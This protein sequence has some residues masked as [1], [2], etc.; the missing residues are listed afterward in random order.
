MRL[1]TRVLPYIFE[2][3]DWRG[4]FWS[5][6]PGQADDNEV[7]TNKLTIEFLNF[8]MPENFAV[9]YLKFKQRGQTLGYFVK[10]MQ[11]DLQTVKTLIRLLQNPIWV[12]T[13][14][15]NLFVR[16]LRIITVFNLVARKAILGISDQ[17]RHKPGCTVKEDG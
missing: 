14:C 5:T 8:R 15:P 10:K 12:Y 6:L 1:L 7:Y 11:M 2:D 9:I 16:I 3:P 4:F 17:V 13:V